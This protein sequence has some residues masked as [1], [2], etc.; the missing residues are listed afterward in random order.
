MRILSVFFLCALFTIKLDAQDIELIIHETFKYEPVGTYEIIIDFEVI[1]ISDEEQIVFEV[2]TV[3]ELP[4]NWTSSLCF[5]ETC[6]ASWVDSIA[7]SPPFP[8]PPLPA[9]DTLKTS[10]H[11]F[12]DTANLNIGT[13]FVQIQVG[14]FSNPNDRF[15]IDFVIT[16]DPSVDVNEDEVPNGY[17]LS[18]NFP[19]PFNPSTRIQY[20]VKEGGFVTLKIYNVLGNEVAALVN[21]YKPAGVYE[22]YFDA[23]GLSSGVYFYR[24]SVNG[25]VQTRKMILEK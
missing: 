20:G 9:G 23:S 22:K 21:E 7:T 2:R 11:V 12:T 3:N 18:Q 19:N 25:N 24:L 16:N 14:T 17:F 4:L 8:E 13:T 10:I 15:T 5:G 6:F 1:N